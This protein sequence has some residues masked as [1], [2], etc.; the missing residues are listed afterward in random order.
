MD[1]HKI[2]T[3]TDQGFA[4]LADLPFLESFFFVSPHITDESLAVMGGWGALRQVRINNADRI[5]D[6]GM[7]QLARCRRLTNIFV[8]RNVSWEG[9]ARLRD[10]PLQ[11]L[12]VWGNKQIDDEALRQLAPILEAWPLTGLDAGQTGITDEGLKYL[13]GLRLEW[14]DVACDGVSDHANQALLDKIIKTQ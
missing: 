10:V 9:I 11:T 6:E 1:L 7:T 5:T 3:F 8:P 14:C 12:V 13:Q 4:C 2:D